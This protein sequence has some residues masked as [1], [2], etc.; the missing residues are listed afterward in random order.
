MQGLELRARFT[1]ILGRFPL[2]RSQGGQGQGVDRLTHL[3]GKGIIDHPVALYWALPLKQGRDD[4][5]PIMPA[6]RCRSSM[7]DVRRALLPSRALQSV[8]V[9]PVV[10]LFRDKRRYTDHGCPTA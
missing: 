7:A 4:C 8:A 6:S 2:T 1:F 5:H 10:R 9:R 3:L